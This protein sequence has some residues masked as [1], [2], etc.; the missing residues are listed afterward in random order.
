MLSDVYLVT[1]P[2]V[3]YAEIDLNNIISLTINTIVVIITSFIHYLL[4]LTANL[5]I[6]IIMTYVYNNNFLKIFTKC[7]V[8][9]HI[10]LYY[11]L[12]KI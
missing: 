8:V 7:T 11:V 2:K 12:R 9:E 1:T 3:K 4:V 6:L 5:C 10:S